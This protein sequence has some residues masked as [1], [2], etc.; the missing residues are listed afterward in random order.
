MDQPS[1]LPRIWI[2]VVAHAA[3]RPHQPTVA[4]KPRSLTK[5]DMI[6]HEMLSN[7]RKVY[8]DGKDTSMRSANLAELY[9][10]IE[11]AG[12]QFITGC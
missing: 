7:F 6:G 9:T 1:L 5:G 4:M 10:C 2:A 8:D 3:S 12:L 11:N